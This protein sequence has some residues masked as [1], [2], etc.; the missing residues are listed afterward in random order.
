MDWLRKVGGHD[1]DGMFFDG[2][3]DIEIEIV[4]NRRENDNTFRNSEND[5]EKGREIFGDPRQL[6]Y[7]FVLN[8]FEK[9]ALRKNRMELRKELEDA[10]IA[11]LAAA[12]KK[13]KRKRSKK[14]WRTSDRIVIVENKNIIKTS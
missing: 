13:G 7:D 10:A 6:A 5:K 1:F 3:N 11:E 9:W 12:K 14:N 2:E 8:R 4:M